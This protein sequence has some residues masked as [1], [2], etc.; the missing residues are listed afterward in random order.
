MSKPTAYVLCCLL[1][2]IEDLVIFSMAIFLSL[3]LENA[4]WMWL[5][6]LCTTTSYFKYISLNR[7]DDKESDFPS[8][9]SEGTVTENKDK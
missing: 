3:Y 4:K 1:S 6:L 9:K 2:L 7:E 5:L 8:E